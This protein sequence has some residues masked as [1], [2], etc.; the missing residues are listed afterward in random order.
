MEVTKK[1]CQE[2]REKPTINPLTGRK[3]EEN[4]GTYLKLKEACKKYQPQAPPMGPMIHWRYSSEPAVEEENNMIDILTY[5]DE[6]RLPYLEKQEEVSK[7]EINEIIDIIKAGKSMFRGDLD[8]EPAAN[9]VLS[10]AKKIKKEKKLIDD[11]PTY[12]VINE[13]REEVKPER[14]HMRGI[15]LGIWSRLTS[16]MRTMKSSLKTKKINILILP[17]DIYNTVNDKKYLDYLIENKIFTYDDIYKRTFESE[18]D[19]VE[20]QDL[21]KKYSELYKQLKGKSPGTEIKELNKK[22]AKGLVKI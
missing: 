4:K 19:F 15:V 6:E 9:H 3:I 16:D 18:K 14:L 7:M 20:L 5:Y 2:F 17:A 21:F 8:N 1:Q 11:V 22:L 13:C 10:I 12:K